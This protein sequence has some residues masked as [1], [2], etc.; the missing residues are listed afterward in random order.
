MSQD[1]DPVLF[2]VFFRL[3]GPGAPPPPSPVGSTCSYDGHSSRTAS[4]GA[5][6]FNQHEE[7]QRER[8]KQEL[9]HKI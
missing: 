6:Y 5:C 9:R 2:S 3:A 8:K 1:K 4:E 7:R